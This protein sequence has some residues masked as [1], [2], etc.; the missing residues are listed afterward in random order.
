MEDIQKI[1]DK[2]GIFDILTDNGIRALQVSV[3]LGF[4]LIP[5]KLG[6]DLSDNNNNE[7][8]LKTTNIKISK[9]YGSATML[10]KPILE[11]FRNTKWIFGEFVG[12][13]LQ[14]IYFIHAAQLE[15][16]YFKKWETIL[17]TKSHIGNPK[18]DV[19]KIRDIGE[20]KYDAYF[21]GGQ[22]PGDQ[23]IQTEFVF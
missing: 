23:Y 13:R 14:R 18:I 22:P 1:A 19:L 5:G 15:D 3:A 10:T 16:I 17:Q 12:F 2:Q 20:L 7:Y 8:E 6:N 21:P 9:S 11:R 4:K